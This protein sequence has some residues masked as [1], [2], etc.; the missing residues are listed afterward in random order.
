MCIR[1]CSLLGGKNNNTEDNTYCFI[2]TDYYRVYGPQHR[3]IIDAILLNS[4][5]QVI[6]QNKLN[7]G[8]NLFFVIYNNIICAYYNYALMKIRNF[9]RHR[10]I[11]RLW[12][13]VR[14]AVDNNIC[15]AHYEC[16][17]RNKRQGTGLRRNISSKRGVTGIPLCR[18]I[19]MRPELV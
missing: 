19:I 18:I 10:L 17:V 2:F 6:K 11:L 16:H 9:P 15:I 13:G 1:T 14:S 5:N 4:S 3:E 12:R 8:C 7:F